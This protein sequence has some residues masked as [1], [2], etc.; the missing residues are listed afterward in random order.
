LFEWKHYK[1][2]NSEGKMWQ[3]FVEPHQWK[4]ALPNRW[5][6]FPAFQTKLQS[7]KSKGRERKT[8]PFQDLKFYSI[9]Q[10]MMLYGLFNSG[11]FILKHFLKYPSKILPHVDM[12]DQTE[13]LHLKRMNRKACWKTFFCILYSSKV[14]KSSWA[15]HFNCFAFTV[16]EI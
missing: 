12:N 7:K 1:N 16:F 3:I 15:K 2:Y 14:C 11:N 13:I 9:F 4:P 10:K 5:C 8:Y 6:T